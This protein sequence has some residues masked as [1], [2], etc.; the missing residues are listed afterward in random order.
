MNTA[1]V[2]IRKK[3]RSKD[4]CTYEGFKEVIKEERNEGM[5]QLMKEERN[6]PRKEGIKEGKKE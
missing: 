1:Y 2:K 3:E 6:E 4:E 5:K